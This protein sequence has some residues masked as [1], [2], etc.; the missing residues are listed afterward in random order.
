MLPNLENWLAFFK[1]SESNLRNEIF[2]KLDYEDFGNINQILISLF[3]ADGNI[4]TVYK[5][6]LSLSS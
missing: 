6:I 1:N 4:F 3:P 2:Y 5:N